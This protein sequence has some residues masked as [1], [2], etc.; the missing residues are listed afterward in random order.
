MP[1]NENLTVHLKA[2]DYALWRTGYVVAGMARSVTALSR[3]RP[4]DGSPGPVPPDSGWGFSL[5]FE[6]RKFR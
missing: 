5:T 1:T 6:F 3:R 2:K 4:E